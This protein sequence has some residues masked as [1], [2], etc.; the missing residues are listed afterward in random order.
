MQ[1]LTRGDLLSLEQY[2]RERVA[3]RARVLAHKKFRT[4]AIGP[5]MTWIFEDRLSVQYQVQE[6]LRT[7][8]IFEDDA[9]G[10]ELAAY[11]PLIPDGTNWKVTQL[12]EFPDPEERR[13]RL[14]ALKD[15]E[16]HCYAEIAGTT[17]CLAVADEDL[18]RSNDEKTSA[19]H[20]L[21]FELGAGRVAA[22]CAGATLVLGVDHPQYPHR[23]TVSDASL[24]VL[25]EDF[26]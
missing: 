10:E 16:Q 12:I 14:S 9:I 24:R 5:N 20:F 13:V 6:M 18:E 8:R 4:V 22:L 15:V 26:A 11:N 17:R 21:R 7:E 3:Y 19:V 23:V 25:I 1:K 2:A